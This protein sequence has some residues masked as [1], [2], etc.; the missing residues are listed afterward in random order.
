MSTYLRDFVGICVISTG[1]SIMWS[2][3]LPLNYV[4]LSEGKMRN[5]KH[6]P[7]NLY[8]TRMFQN[9]RLFEWFGKKSLVSEKQDL[10]LKQALNCTP[11]VMYFIKF[12]VYNLG[13]NLWVDL[14]K[15]IVMATLC[16]RWWDTK[17]NQIWPLTFTSF[18]A[19]AAPFSSDNWLDA[20][21]Y[22]SREF[23]VAIS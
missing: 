21:S 3:W 13:F 10:F 5:W 15:E 22:L 2:R 16:N 7:F 14:L 9:Q 20:K 12:I 1:L 4:V 23:N 19:I 11:Q 17:Q 18:E 6:L 8:I